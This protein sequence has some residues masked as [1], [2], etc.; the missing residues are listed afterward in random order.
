MKYS[1]S[2][3]GRKGSSFKLKE[4]YVND[5]IKTNKNRINNNKLLELE[6][7]KNKSYNNYPSYKNGSGKSLSG[8]GSR[9]SGNSKNSNIERQSYIRKYEKSDFI[10]KLEKTEKAVLVDT[11]YLTFSNGLGSK[12]SQNYNGI[13]T[14]ENSSKRP[15]KVEFVRK[16]RPNNSID[17]LNLKSETNHK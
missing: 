1:D 17:F 15:V 4:E 14:G 5:I 9:F 7:I 6:E 2:Q 12:D 16:H 8:S 13:N 11:N 10:G 3:S